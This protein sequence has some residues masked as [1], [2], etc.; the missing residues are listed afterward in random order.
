MGIE[1]SKAAGQKDRY[2]SCSDHPPWTQVA[3]VPLDT[4]KNVCDP[5]FGIDYYS[6]WMNKQLKVQKRPWSRFNV[7]GK[8]EVTGKQEKVCSFS[9]CVSITGREEKLNG[10]LKDSSVIALHA[11]VV[12]IQ[13]VLPRAVKLLIVDW[14]ND[15]LLATYTFAFSKEPCVQECF[16]SPDATV[17]LCRQN[18]WLRRKLGH[19]TSFDPNIRVIQIKDGLCHR[20]FV[21]EDSLAYGVFGSAISMHPIFASGRATLLSSTLQMRNANTSSVDDVNNIQVFDFKRRQ[22]SISSDTSLDHVIH[23]AKHSPDGRFLVAVLVN[24][25]IYISCTLRAHELRIYDS[26]TLIPLHT[27]PLFDHITKQH[28]LQSFP[29]FSRDVQ[30]LAQP[31]S[32]TVNV[33][34]LPQ[35]GYSLQQLCRTVIRHHTVLARVSQLPLPSAV[36]AFLEF[37][38]PRES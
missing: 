15:A 27:M 26:D 31:T 35:D 28:L 12:V 24:V 20:L 13:L 36:I 38:S 30:C 33:L 34:R 22:L 3:C 19:V 17:M 11:R 14:H 10:W 32:A 8:N 29:M 23:H 2:G 7:H 21:I 18:F 4:W 1:N 6:E 16:V 37:R 25:S 5:V 9:C